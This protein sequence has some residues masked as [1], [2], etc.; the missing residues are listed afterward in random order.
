M[1]TDATIIVLHSGNYEF[2]CVRH[3]KSN[4]LYVSDIIHP[5]SCKAPAY[6]KLHI[7]LYIAAVHDAIERM[8]LAETLPADQ[9]SKIPSN[10]AKFNKREKG[11]RD[12]DKD[13]P[14]DG[15]NAGDRD[16]GGRGGKR[17]RR[18]KDDDGPPQGGK[19]RGRDRQS[20][21]S[22]PRTRG[23]QKSEHEAQAVRVLFQYIS[24]S[25]LIKF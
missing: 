17:Q 14:G 23:T 1:R 16:G 11:E 22:R 15:G 8:R 21:S 24:T 18:R 12:D 3:R 9:R 13:R 6:G 20:S 19:G 10:F 5:P 2:V 7:G 4:T 25:Y